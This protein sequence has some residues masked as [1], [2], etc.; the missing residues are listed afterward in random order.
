MKRLLGVMSAAAGS[1]AGCAARVAVAW[2]A[3]HRHPWR[4]REHLAA[5]SQRRCGDPCW[6]HIMAAGSAAV[7]LRR[8]RRCGKQRQARH[9]QTR[10]RRARGPA[11]RPAAGKPLLHCC[12]RHA[13]VA[14][15]PTL[16]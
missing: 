15:A 16:A 3:L 14:P 9:I 10:R 4:R 6:R 13:A 11:A 5:A 12:C 7:W 1:A 2:G 8:Q